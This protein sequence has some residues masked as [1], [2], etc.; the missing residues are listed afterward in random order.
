[1]AVIF[2]E[3]HDRVF[4]LLVVNIAMVTAEAK[5]AIPPSANGVEVRRRKSF[6]DRA[7]EERSHA[8]KGKQ[9]VKH[10]FAAHSILRHEITRLAPAALIISVRIHQMPG[11]IGFH[12]TRSSLIGSA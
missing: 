1:M 8:G 10:G 4:P 2:V 9:F 3:L 11:G 5:I 12:P 6:A 7:V